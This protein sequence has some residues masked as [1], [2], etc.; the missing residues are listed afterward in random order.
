MGFPGSGHCS[1]ELRPAASEQRGAVPGTTAISVRPALGLALL[2]LPPTGPPAAPPAFVPLLPPSS[3]PGS[4]AALAGRGSRGKQGHSLGTGH[5]LGWL[6]SAPQPLVASQRWGLGL[7]GSSPPGVEA[8]RCWPGWA[9]SSRRVCAGV[10]RSQVAPSGRGDSGA[11]S[12]RGKHRGDT[13]QQSEGAGQT[14]WRPGA[15]LFPALAGHAPKVSTLLL[16]PCP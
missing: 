10:C 5:G 8:Q 4:A 16:G 13:S 6:L 3:S 12:A 1:P 11:P 2:R 15:S 14:R 9:P 7:P